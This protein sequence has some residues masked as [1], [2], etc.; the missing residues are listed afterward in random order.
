VS[1]FTALDALVDEK[2]H[3]TAT[4]GATAYVLL[5]EETEILL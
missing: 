1:V 4:F 2:N 3:E 5:L